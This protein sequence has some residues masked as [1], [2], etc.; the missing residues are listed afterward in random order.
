MYEVDRRENGTVIITDW[1]G[2]VVYSVNQDAWI[3]YR[4]RE[5]SNPPSAVQV[6]TLKDGELIEALTNAVKIA[7]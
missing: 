5:G 6:K 3:V 4:Q 7:L 2:D 1:K